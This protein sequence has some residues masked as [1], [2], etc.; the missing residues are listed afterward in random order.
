MNKAVLWIII[1]VVVLAGLYWAMSGSSAPVAPDTTG[2]MA[3]STATSTPVGMMLE[4]T[5][6]VSEQAAG[7]EVVISSV[8]LKEDASIVVHKDAAGSPDVAIGSVTLKAGSYSDVKIALTES[9]KSGD[10]VYAMLHGDNGDGKYTEAT[11]STP[12]K[13]AT[14]T[15]L[16]TSVKVK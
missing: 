15:I 12:L 8:T 7:K 5:L 3:T 9:V 1:L 11:E 6:T 2:S 13:N 4:N 10:T 14:G 16:M